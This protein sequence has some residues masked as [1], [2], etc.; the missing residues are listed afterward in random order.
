MIAIGERRLLRFAAI[1]LPLLSI[2]AWPYP[3]LGRAYRFVVCRAIND[4][5]MNST[6]TPRVA[7]LVPDP[8]TGFE[9]HGVVAVWDQNANSV[10]EQFPV[11]IHQTFYL[12]T[13]VFAVLTIAGKFTW[14]GRQVPLKLLVG[15][16]ESPIDAL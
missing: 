12:P 8:R 9:W 1:F 5:V 3:F 4:M 13:V 15:I 11:D 2:L 6:D 7:R 10:Q 14:G 16:Q